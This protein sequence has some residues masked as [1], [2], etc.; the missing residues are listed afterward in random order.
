[1]QAK[2]AGEP[3]NAASA[4]TAT[5]RIYVQERIPSMPLKRIVELEMQVSLVESIYW[6]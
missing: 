1:M 5:S 3:A 6:P 2:D 4:R